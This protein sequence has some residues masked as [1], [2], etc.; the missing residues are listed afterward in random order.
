MCKMCSAL[1][2]IHNKCVFC[3]HG[4][5]FETSEFSAYSKPRNIKQ[6]QVPNTKLELTYSKHQLLILGIKT[7]F[8]SVISIL[9]DS[10]KHFLQQ[11]YSSNIF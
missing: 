4:C 10:D 2:S 1:V 7:S 6:P 8:I 5:M 3:L 11:I 9:S